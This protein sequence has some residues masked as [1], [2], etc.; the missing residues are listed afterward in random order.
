MCRE[1][2]SD[3]QKIVIIG[4]TAMTAL[5]TAPGHETYASVDGVLFSA[6]RSKLI[7]YPRGRTGSYRVPDGVRDI[8]E[9]AFFGSALSEVSVPESVTDIGEAA[10]RDCRRLSRVD[11]AEGLL[12][13]GMDAFWGCTALTEFFLP[14]SLERAGPDAFANCDG[15]ERMVIPDAQERRASIWRVPK[16][17]TIYTKTDWQAVGE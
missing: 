15:L 8:G 16:T 13:I 7:L 2:I 12:A 1:K 17:C 5:E 3:R 9:R 10:F 11:L 4:C 6:D 14:D